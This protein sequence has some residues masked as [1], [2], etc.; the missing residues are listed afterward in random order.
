MVFQDYFLV[1]L[2]RG[3]TSMRLL[4]LLAIGHSRMFISLFQL[5]NLVLDGRILGVMDL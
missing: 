3:I 2:L 5:K 4:A 1:E